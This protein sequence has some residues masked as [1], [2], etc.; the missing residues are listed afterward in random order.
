MYFQRKLGTVLYYNKDPRA[1][2][3]RYRGWWEIGRPTTLS[4]LETAKAF[5]AP[6]LAE[7]NSND[8]VRDLI[9]N[10]GDRNVQYGTM[11]WRGKWDNEV[12]LRL[13]EVG[14]VD[15]VRTGTIFTR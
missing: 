4:P 14:T 6:L 3:P 10:V 1:N 8:K 9:K 15:N 2:F 5:G 11:R 12:T 13:A 7:C